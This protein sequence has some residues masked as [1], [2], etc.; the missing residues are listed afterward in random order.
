MVD[1]LIVYFSVEK[2][3]IAKVKQMLLVVGVARAGG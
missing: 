3:L 2:Y 1:G